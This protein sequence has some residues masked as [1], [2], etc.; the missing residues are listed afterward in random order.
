MS[1]SN[2][3]LKI[4]RKKEFSLENVVSLHY[5]GFVSISFEGV[6]L[7]V[8]I[9]FPVRAREEIHTEIG[10][11][12]P[13]VANS[14]ADYREILIWVFLD[15]MQVIELTTELSYFLTHAPILKNSS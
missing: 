6:T 5:K 14:T 10:S 11:D 1:W 7:R 3:T 2:I 9:E 4:F 13:H 15:Q 8:L 12:F